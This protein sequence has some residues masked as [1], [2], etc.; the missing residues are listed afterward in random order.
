MVREPANPAPVIAQLS[1]A[2]GALSAERGT[3]Y[4]KDGWRDFRAN[5]N[6]SRDNQ[7]FQLFA[8]YRTHGIAV[9]RKAYNQ[10][11]KE[12]ERGTIKL[13]RR[14]IPRV[15]TYTAW[16]DQG[17]KCHRCKNDMPVFDKDVTGDHVIAYHQATEENKDQIHTPE[18]IRALHRHCNSAKGGR[19]LFTEATRSGRT[20][21]EMLRKT[22]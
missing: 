2:L 10:F 18:N 20:V 11:V 12:S 15:W 16:L 3:K 17:K 22:I 6:R 13:K 7:A 8:E 5:P 19:D 14:A 9:L 21:V 4:I 1:A